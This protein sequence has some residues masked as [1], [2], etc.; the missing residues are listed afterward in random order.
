MLIEDSFEID[1]EIKTSF[2]T[3]KQFNL[4]CHYFVERFDRIDHND[5]WQMELKS[6]V[7][8]NCLLILLNELNINLLIIF[9]KIGLKRKLSYI[10]IIK[11]INIS[12]NDKVDLNLSESASYQLAIRIIYHPN[13]QLPVLYFNMKIL[14]YNT[15]YDEDDCELEMEIETISLDLLKIIKILN[16]EKEKNS[17]GDS[18]YEESGLEL[19][20][21][22]ITPNVSLFNF[23]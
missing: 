3:Q 10:E 21:G 2:I 18:I 13:Y 7:C 5:N 9:V 14:E 16:F 17:N 4:C 19:L 23:N 1:D 8:L 20:K 6:L 11:Q 12:N 15:Y 22:N